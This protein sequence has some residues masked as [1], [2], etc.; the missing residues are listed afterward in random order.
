MQKSLEDSGYKVLAAQRCRSGRSISEADEIAA[1]VLDLG[2]PKI[3]GWE[4]LKGMR[5]AN[6]G[7]KLILASGYLSSDK[8]AAANESSHV[9]MKPYL[10]DEVLAKISE[11]I[12]H[13]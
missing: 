2:L 5:K 1:V 4:A 9:I 6:P 3:T 8:N 12:R 7:V 11:V 10:L 13:P